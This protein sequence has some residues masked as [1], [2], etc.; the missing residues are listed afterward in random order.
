MARDRGINRPELD[1]AVADGRL[2]RPLLGVYVDEAFELTPLTRAQAAGLVV[3]AHSIVRDR[4]AAWVWG[5]ECF[6]FAELDG[7]PAL[8]TCVL[9]GHEPTERE[10]VAGITRDLLPEDWIEVAGV[11]VTT[12]LRTA[13]DLGCTLRPFVALG[14]MDALMRHHGFSHA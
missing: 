3:S 13:L 7:T 11:P 10:E 9:R 2:V 14:A 5:V 6:W 4:T 12:P 1:R 8:E